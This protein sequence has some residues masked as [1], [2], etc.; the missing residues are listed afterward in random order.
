MLHRPNS[1]L[2][3]RGRYSETGRV[4][5]VTAVVYQR[6]PVFTDLFLGRLL[7]AELKRAHDLGLVASLAWV[8]MPDHLHWMF[9]L[10]DATLPQVMQQVKSRST[11][12]INRNCCTRG[13]FWQHGYHDRAARAEEDLVKIARYIIANPL[14]ARLVE[15]IGDYSLWDATWL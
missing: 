5:L 8:I 11:L 3:R 13:A 7:V 4:Y 12:T 9:E 10:R 14:R 2:L 6:R 15:H 1:H